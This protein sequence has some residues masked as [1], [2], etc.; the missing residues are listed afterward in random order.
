[1]HKKAVLLDVSSVSCVLQALILHISDSICAHPTHFLERQ[2]RPRRRYFFSNSNSFWPRV[3]LH[4]GWKSTSNSHQ[5]WSCLLSDV[6][7]HGQLYVASSRAMGRRTVC[8]LLNDSRLH[9]YI[10]FGCS[11]Y[12]S[13]I[14]LRIH[15]CNLTYP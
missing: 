5:S 6:S 1:M 9:Q 13:P 14:D 15:Q 11:C 4:N 2:R 8:C 12:T 10:G 7:S 3:S